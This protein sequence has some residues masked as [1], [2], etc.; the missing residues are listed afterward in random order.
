MTNITPGRRDVL[1]GIAAG[2]V[3]LTL[4]GV[5]SA[6][7]QTQY[8]VRVRGRT[9]TARLE[10]K[11]Y[12]IKEQ[13]ADGGVLVV[14]GPED[15]LDDV[16][17]VRGVRVAVPDFE[18]E[19]EEPVET[20]GFESSDD[21]PAFW[22]FQWDKHVTE[23]KEAHETATG[24]GSTVAIIDTGIDHTHQD[25]GNVDV[26]DSAS[27]IE[28]EVGPHTGDIGAH[29]T[30]VAGIA[31]ATGAVGVLGTAPDAELVSVR[32][33]PE[34]GLATF[35]DV[36]M[37]MEY[38]ADIGA[39]AAN[40]SL[41]TLPIPPQANAEQFRRIMEPVAQGVTKE[42]TL[43]VG[44][45]GN[46]DANLQQG[47]F[48]TLPNSLAGVVSTSATGPNDLRTFYSNYG[49]NEIDVGAPG[50]GYETLEKTLETDPS[51]V[52]FPFPTN[53]VLSTIPGDE[54]AWFAGTSM[55]A[56]QVAGTAALVRAEHPGANARQVENAI[57]QGA[58]LVRGRSDPDLGAGRLNA[59]DALDG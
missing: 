20:D 55:A 51:E 13:L 47:G 29:G 35:G 5:V 21:H 30:H 17:G 50:G 37:A 7:G 52:E 26:A 57:K 10:R 9:T 48:F 40:M 54:Y 46:S 45:A 28:G 12:E 38:A 34:E 31:A 36:L 24:S 39:D 19:L 44:S 53:L 58:D 3:S 8:I 15:S 11:G 23:V 59:N 27:I 41:G 16:R 32:V 2:G 56:P 6:D 1:K 22:D 4:A 18:F 43:L 14:V 42:G 33:F 49:T 25:L